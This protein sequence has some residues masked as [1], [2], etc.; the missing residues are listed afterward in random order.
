MRGADGLLDLRLDLRPDGC[1][2]Y[3]TEFGSAF[4][5]GPKVGI[6]TTAP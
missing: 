6:A 4:R 2:G 5:N 3:C 1:S